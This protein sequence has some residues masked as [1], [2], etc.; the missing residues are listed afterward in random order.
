M[1]KF[2]VLGER[3]APKTQDSPDAWIQAIPIPSATSHVQV[4]E[5]AHD[6]ED[7]G[8]FFMYSWATLELEEHR[9]FLTCL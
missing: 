2:Q 3:P 7:S 9:G 4:I 5:M 8:T 1:F 6:A